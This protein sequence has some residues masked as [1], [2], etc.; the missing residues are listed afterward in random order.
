MGFCVCFAGRRLLWR[1]ALRTQKVAQ[2]AGST[3]HAIRFDRPRE[4]QVCVHLRGSASSPSPRLSA[5]WTSSHPLIILRSECETISDPLRAADGGSSPYSCVPTRK[6]A[7]SECS[8]AL[9]RP[10]PQL[11]VTERACKQAV[12]SYR[13]A[14]VK[15][16]RQRAQLASLGVHPHGVM[17]PPHSAG[18]ASPRPTSSPPQGYHLNSGLGSS[19]T[20]PLRIGSALASPLLIPQQQWGLVDSPRHVIVVEESRWE[21]ERGR[22]P[23]S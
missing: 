8:R 23:Q 3:R 11:H 9:P 20:P 21:T 7:A 12:E 6:R 4:V 5:R 2:R 13:L 1:L 14:S 18:P 16:E 19:S 17:S 15:L 22:S 10:F